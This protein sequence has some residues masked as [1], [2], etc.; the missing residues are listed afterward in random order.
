MQVY[1]FQ[2]PSDDRARK[3]LGAVQSAKVKNFWQSRHV[4]VTNLKR[5]KSMPGKTARVSNGSRRLSLVEREERK[6]VQEEDKHR[7]DAFKFD[8]A[9]S[10]EN[11]EK[12]ILSVAFLLEWNSEIGNEDVNGFAAYGLSKFLRSA[13]REIKM[14]RSRVLRESG[15]TLAAGD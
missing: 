5:R 7:L 1:R 2:S 11:C 13:A 4:Y 8:G 9:G 14:H 6:R 15:I 12:A 10:V 3:S